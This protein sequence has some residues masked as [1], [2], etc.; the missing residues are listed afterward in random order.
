MTGERDIRSEDRQLLL[1]AICAATEKLVI[2]YTGANEYSGQPP[3]ARGAAGRAARRA[4]HDDPGQGP[5]AHRHRASV[6]AVRHSQRHP[7]RARCPA[8]RSPSTRPR[9]ARRRC[10]SGERAEHPQFISEP[11]PPPPPETCPRR[12]GRLLQRP[13]QGVLPR[14]RL[15]AAAGT[16][17]ASQDAMP[18]E[19][20]ALEQWT[21]GD[22]MLH[23]MLR[24][25]ASR[26][27]ARRRSGAAARCRPGQLGWRKAA[28]IRDQAAPA[29]DRSAAA[30]A[31][32][33]R[34]GLRRRHRPRRWSPADRHGVA[35]VRR[36]PGV[37]DVLQAG[38][39]APARVVDSAAGV[40]RS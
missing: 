12:S 5:R 11:L 1:D 36:S 9:C 27:G 22:R 33:S 32:R 18:V 34:P 16:S 7:R 28:E 6:A 29:G 14:A 20:D 19:I 37:G 30:P 2:T 31:R 38:R 21:V 23:D 4:R 24:G 35:G 8:S 40:G 15:H 17:T 3:P 10:R 26:A 25:M 13:G 39:Q